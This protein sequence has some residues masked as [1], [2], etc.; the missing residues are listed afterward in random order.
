MPGSNSC[1]NVSGEASGAAGANLKTDVH[2]GVVF[3]LVK[4]LREPAS[5]RPKPCASSLEK[6]RE[7]CPFATPGWPSQEEKQSWREISFALGNL[8]VRPFDSRTE[9][10]STPL[11]RRRWS[12]APSSP[13]LV[14]QCA[15]SSSTV[16]TS[17]TLRHNISTMLQS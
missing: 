10:F 12:S 5:S 15:Q 7:Y 1:P 4:P 6:P 13:N 16:I 3:E 17:C 8:T 14:K 9:G 2:A 11:A